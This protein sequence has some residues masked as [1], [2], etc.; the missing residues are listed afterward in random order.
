MNHCSLS[1][2]S[3]PSTFFG[4]QRLDRCRGG[5]PIPLIAKSPGFLSRPSPNVL[6]NPM[7]L[8]QFFIHRR[9]VGLKDLLMLASSK[10]VTLSTASFHIR[11]L[12]FFKSH[13]CHPTYNIISYTANK[14]SPNEPERWL[15]EWYPDPFTNR[16]HPQ[17]YNAIVNA[18]SKIRKIK[19]W[20]K[21]CWLLELSVLV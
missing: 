17:N 3:S 2:L 20:P 4:H 15:D 10:F 14:K 5:V 6:F 8:M 1:N 18:N 7:L 13:V 12:T 16:R 21:L 9:G 19:M 11:S